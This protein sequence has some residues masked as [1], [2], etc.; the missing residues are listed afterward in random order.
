MTLIQTSETL[1][2]FL[3]ILQIMG[4]PLNCDRKD[5][6]GRNGKGTK[7][8]IDARV[9]G[10]T[11]QTPVL[12]LQNFIPHPSPLMTRGQLITVGAKETK[13]SHLR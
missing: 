3:F 5:Q 6:Y 2:K 4:E 9:H 12:S 11:H 1:G 10:N 13:F 8:E 7:K